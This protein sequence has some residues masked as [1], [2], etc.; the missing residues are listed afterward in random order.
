M[1]FTNRVS[2]KRCSQLRPS[3]CPFVCFHSSLL[4]RLTF[5]PHLLHLYGVMTHDHS[6]PGVEGGGQRS[7]LGRYDLE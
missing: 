1:Y 5:D 7:K 2:E 3:L 4:N 6:P